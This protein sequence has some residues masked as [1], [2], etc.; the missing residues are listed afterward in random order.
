MS[1]DS[2]LVAAKTDLEVKDEI[3]ATP[4]AVLTN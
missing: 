4:A 1:G 2:A 3:A